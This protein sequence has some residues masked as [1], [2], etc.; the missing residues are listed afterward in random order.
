MSYTAIIHFREPVTLATAETEF[1][2][3]VRDLSRQYTALRDRFQ[4][5]AN[6]MPVAELYCKGERFGTVTY[7]GT[8][9]RRTCDV[10]GQRALIAEAV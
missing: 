7:S 8:V 6:V 3:A 2:D 9:W 10:S 1:L 5:S 4:L